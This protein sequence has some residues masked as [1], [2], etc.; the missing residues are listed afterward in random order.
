MNEPSASRTEEPAPQVV[1]S[2]ADQPGIYYGWVMLV[3]AAFAMTAT[4]PG[5]THGLGLITKPLIEDPAFGTNEVT[6]SALNFW[7]IILGS[8]LCLPVGRL[9]DRFGVRLV[10]VG[11]AAALGACVLWMSATSGLIAL[12][13]ALTLVRGLGQGS[14][15]VVSMAMVGKWFT[16]RLPIA[17]AIF[18]IL[19]SI[20]FIVSFQVFG[21]AVKSHGWRDSWAGLGLVLLVG[22]APLA[23]LLARSTPES[24]G[25]AP[26]REEEAHE[27]SDAQASTLATALRSPSFWAFTSAACLFN[28]IWSAITLLSEN[29]LAS[30]GMNHDTYVDVMSMMVLFGL[31]ANFISGWLARRFSMG[32]VLAFGMVML[33]GA[34]LAFP[35]LENQTHAL[36]YGAQLG[37]A[38]GIVT[39]IFF[40]FYGHEF[41]RAHL[42]SIQ[43][44][45]Q[46]LSV[47]ASALG[48]LLL[49]LCRDQLGSYDLFFYVAA[50]VALALAVIVPMVRTVRQ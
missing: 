19:L 47:F 33:A 31:P 20:G 16:R 17:M 28:M 24:I 14:L 22:L 21:A 4:L 32:R 41:G 12:F 9:I 36:L 8:A 42:G 13:I 18:T 6:L 3:L 2:R 35:N 50:P 7:A 11:V 43:A 46:V 27:R 26:D 30:R 25:V 49:A 1:A 34:L 5:R 23:L 37:I 10:L 15:S 45:A 38:G 29:L 39:V 40:A 44:A 48:P